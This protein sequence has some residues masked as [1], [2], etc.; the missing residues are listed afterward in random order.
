[1]MVM[2]QKQCF[3]SAFKLCQTYHRSTCLSLKSITW[4]M[5]TSLTRVSWTRQIT[6]G[7]GHKMTIS[8]SSKTQTTRSLI[9][10]KHNAIATKV[11]KFIGKN[12]QVSRKMMCLTNR[13][14]FLSCTTTKNIHRIVIVQ[15]RPR[16][17]DRE[18]SVQARMALKAISRP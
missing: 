3:R 15:K 17:Q 18:S 9:K 12:L 6:T 5:S 16:I 8:V 10:V 13:V 1:M 4:A 7:L 14:C 11:R 2:S